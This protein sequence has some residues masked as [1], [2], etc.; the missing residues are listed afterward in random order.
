MSER[1][2]GGDQGRWDM[3]YRAYVGVVFGLAYRY[4]LM[5]ALVGLGLATRL[6][7]L[8]ISLDEVDAAAYFNALKYGYNISEVHP[9]P[10]G[11]PVYVFMAGLLNVPLQDPLLS[12]TLLSA[13]FG[14]I[15][16]VPFNLL[17]KELGLPRAAVLAGSLFFIFNPLLWAYSEAALSDVPAMFFA[18]TLA[19]LCFRA[20]RSDAAFLAAA[21]V[22]SLLLGVRTAYNP[23]LVLLCFPIVYRLVRYRATGVIRLF[24]VGALL[25]TLVSLVWAIP[26]IVIGGP[27][28][29]SYVTWLGRV[30]DMV[31]DWSIVEVGPP[32]ASNIFFRVVRFASGYFLT[33]PWTGSG[34]T[35]ALGL[36]LILPWL[37]GFAL[38][39]VN[40]TP[41]PPKEGVGLAS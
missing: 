40:F 24:L 20:R 5:L 18:I 11:N 31:G 19:Y 7:L 29:G 23:L 14:S 4:K 12:L 37:F 30:S 16:V 21:I 8:S 34:A 36:L 38:F 17:L 15:A 3:R 26:M 10:P 9:H 13:L 39:F 25:F 35:S 41:N 22:A 2:T 28:F 32:W 1:L 27:G 6:P 33:Y